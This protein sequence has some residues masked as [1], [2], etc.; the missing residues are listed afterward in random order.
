M[1]KIWKYLFTVIVANMLKQNICIGQITLDREVDSLFLSYEFKPVQISPSETKYFFADTLANTFSLY[2]MDFTPFL[3]NIAVPEPF[4]EATIAMQALYISRALFD[5]DTTNIEYAYYSPSDNEKPF[6]IMRTDG[7]QLF[8]LDSANG[9]YCIGGCLGLSDVSRPIINTS[10]G[11]KLFLQKGNAGYVQIF[12]YSLC[13]TLP[14]DIFE[15]PLKD[16]IYVTVF[17]NPSSSTLTF[18]INPPN[19]MSEFELV[20]VDGNARELKRERV[21]PQNQTYVFDSSNI[22]E[23]TYFYTLCTKNKSYQSGKFIILK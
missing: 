3:T 5:C 11:T 20:I 2:N 15:L 1:K 16:Q 18:K 17:P 19:N 4:E 7:T 10:D 22:T 9:P 23:G 14:N 12:I 21:N 8:K 13:G 6:R